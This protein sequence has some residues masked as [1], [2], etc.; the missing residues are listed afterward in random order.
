MQKQTQP[1]KPNSTKH[2]KTKLASFSRFL[3]HLARWI[4]VQTGGAD[5]VDQRHPVTSHLE[6]SVPS[7]SAGLR[8][9]ST[10]S[11]IDCGVPSCWTQ[12]LLMKHLTDAVGHTW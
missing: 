7:T 10:S 9:Q 11:G 4:L 3:Q 1:R 2:C 5:C 6:C 12:Y 8:N